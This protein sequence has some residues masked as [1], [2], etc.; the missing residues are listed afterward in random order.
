[1]EKYKG[2]EF[3]DKDKWYYLIPIIFILLIVPLIVRLKV[4]PVPLSVVDYTGG[5]R[6][7]HDFFS[8]YKMVCFFIATI[9]TLILAVV[10]IL[11]NNFTF[12]RTKIYIPIA[13][14]AMFIAIS[15]ILS[16]NKEVA[17]NGFIDRYEG[18][19]TLI[20]YI[21]IMFLVINMVQT[22]KHIKILIG[23]LFVSAAII[24]TI[25]IFQYLGYDLFKTNIGKAI[26]IPSKYAASKDKLSFMFGERTIYSTLY[27]TNYVG[28]YMAMLFPLSFT[29]FLLTRNKVFKLLMAIFTILM[30]VNL[31][32]SNSRAGLIGG[33]IALILLL[34]MIR[35]LIVRNWPYFVG[36]LFILI[37]VLIGINKYT[38]GSLITRVNSVMTSVKEVAAKGDGGV[39][40]NTRHSLKDVKVDDNGIS[41]ITTT[42]TLKVKVKDGTIQFMDDKD[43]VMNIEYDTNT[44]NIKINDDRYNDY[45]ISYVR[46]D[47]YNLLQCVKQADTFKLNFALIDNKFKILDNNMKPFDIKPTARIGF[48]GKD[49]L[50]SG[51]GYIWSRT[52]PIILDNPLF[53]YGP[54]TFAIAFPQHDIIDRYNFSSG[55]MW[56]VVDKP[57]NL[58]LQIAEGTGIPSLMAFLSIMIMYF[59]SSFRVYFSNEYK[60]FTSI[61]G[62]GIF[63][64]V[65][66]YLITGVFNDSV[67]SVAPVFWVLLGLGICINTMIKNDRNKVEI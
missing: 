13:I 58:Y 9:V 31:Y 50:G 40:Y 8:Y 12:V 2:F 19:Y 30:F 4:I 21:L 59:I 32:G 44:G 61:I 36:A 66:G 49:S 62:V 42:E 1:M 14:Y 33:A 29:I 7:N 3:N 57:H 5:V 45:K 52:F 17:F 65:V 46:Y 28:S 18:G 41:I 11:N 63:V 39:V 26:M 37:F 43:S 24:G 34:V 27:N 35:K 55:D 47:K 56:M 22:Q 23:A 25:G 60:D 6:E 15:T 53:G 67:V 51:R 10:K 54:D 64:G 20:A 38:N 48:E 16:N